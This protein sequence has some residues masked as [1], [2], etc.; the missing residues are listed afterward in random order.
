MNNY[1]NILI[2][3][4]DGYIGSALLNFLKKKKFKVTTLDTGYFRDG[5]LEK[6][7]T[8]HLKTDIRKLKE[9][10]IKKFNVVI[11]L[12]ASQNDPSDAINS[13][14]FYEISKKYTIRVAKICKKNNIKFIFPSS[15]SVYGFGKKEF[16]EKSKTFPLT[17]YSR[18]KIEIETELSKLAC[19]N[20]SP[21][22]LRFSTVFGFSPRIRL[23]LVINMLSILAITSKK[24]ILNSNGLAWR[25][26][27]SMED[28]CLAFFLS[29]KSNI[30]NGKLNIF[31]VGHNNNNIKIINI[32][33]IIAKLTNVKI[34]Y[35]FDKKK[36]L[37]FDRNIKNGADKRSY[38]VNFSK[39]HKTFPQFKQKK[40]LN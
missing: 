10:T 15:C 3:G 28:V 18:N 37:I 8:A 23:D 39:F 27:I 2:V 31:N 36:S 14:K 19:E 6:C 5:T 29:I 26:H 7:P 35:N 38:K 11:F 32:A 33:K 22:A 24:I 17:N 40:T 4:S 16:N 20:F 12:A 21:I 34:H 13:K 1:K 25:P 9:S 30:K